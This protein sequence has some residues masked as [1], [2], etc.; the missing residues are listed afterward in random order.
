MGLWYLGRRAAFPPRLRWGVVAGMVLLV[1]AAVWWYAPRLSLDSAIMNRPR[2]WL[3][4]L[5]LSAMNPGGVG[6]G[7]SG[8]LVQSFMC[9]DL[10]I[11]TLVSTPL[12]LLAEYGW[13]VGLLILWV[14]FLSCIEIGCLF[15]DVY[16]PMPAYWPA[17]CRRI[18]PMDVKPL[19][20]ICLFVGLLLSSLNSTLIDSAILIGTVSQGRLNQI[21]EWILA[22]TFVGVCGWM[23]GRG[24]R[25][26]GWTTHLFSASVLCVS[27]CAPLRALQAETTPRV[28]AGY[29]SVSPHISGVAYHD[30]SWPLA[31]M[32]RLM[33]RF[34]RIRLAPGVPPEVFAKNGLREPVWLFGEVGESAARFAPSF[35][36][37]VSPS[38]LLAPPQNVT[39]IYCRRYGEPCHDSRVVYY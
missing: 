22:L 31:E 36:T 38:S 19:R 35:V 17:F 2:I 23:A 26:I 7:Y 27:L 32:A 6:M 39:A 37:L 28:E 1:G 25:R 8:N 29:V 20:G 18:L 16:Q 3:A 11:R 30:A 4:G 33:Q 10:A 15:W 9:P 34:G 24:A 12:T 5:R 14:V 13:L 21:L